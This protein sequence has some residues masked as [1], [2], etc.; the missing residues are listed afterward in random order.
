MAQAIVTKYFGP[1]NS[2]GSRVKATCDA[3][4]VTVGW[5][6]ALGDSGNYDAA[7][8]KLAKKFGWT[9]SMLRGTLPSGDRVYVFEGGPR[10][11]VSANA[12]GGRRRAAHAAH[13][14]GGKR[15]ARRNRCGC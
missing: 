13:R 8:I 5:D 10:V 7:A 11:E 1:T 12:A 3:G 9:G 4:S 2:K 6:Y 15:T 14:A